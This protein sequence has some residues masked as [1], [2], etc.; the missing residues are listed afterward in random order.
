[1]MPAT[2]SVPARRR[3]SWLPPFIRGSTVAPSPEHESADALGTADLVGGEAQEIGAE[4]RDVELDPP[5]RLDRVGVEDPAPVMDD[6]GSLGHR[7]DRAGFV[8]GCH[9][10]DEGLLARALAT[11]EAAPARLSRL[12]TP[13]AVTGKRVTQRGR[14]PS[15]A[16]RRR[17]LDRR[18]VTAPRL[19]AARRKRERVRLG[20]AAREDHVLWPCACERRH[21][22]PRRLDRAPRSP[23]LG[24]HRG[25]IA[26]KRKRLGDGLAHF[27]PNAAQSRCNRDR[28]AGSCSHVA[29]GH[30]QTVNACTSPLGTCYEARPDV[31]AAPSAQL[32]GSG[33]FGTILIST[34]YRFAA[35]QSQVL[36]PAFP[37][38]KSAFVE[39]LLLDF[40]MTKIVSRPVVHA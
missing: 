2:F 12:A 16:K 10:R 34:G 23:S 17:M 13:S 14:E 7:L 25:R 15:T 37:L 11:R 19:P 4:R 22:L 6:A 33:L 30:S 29:R 31:S 21:L 24:M 40:S 27:V 32:S 26:G 8:V 1:M 3:R 36:Q 5:G 9:Q 18:D 28:S 38:P 39:H 35:P 20:R